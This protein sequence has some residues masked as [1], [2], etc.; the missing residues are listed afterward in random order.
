MLSVL[1][2]LVLSSSP[3]A[4][5][6]TGKLD[7]KLI[8]SAIHA[9]WPAI[10]RCVEEAQPND[11]GLVSV[12]FVIG[13]EGRVTTAELAEPSTAPKVVVQCVL[14]GVMALKTAAPRGGTVE[15]VFPFRIE[16]RGEE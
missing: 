6:Y 2:A 9:Q 7:P 5:A 3:D 11:G 13:R 4:G 8:T 15:V 1:A 14:T 16:Y 10:R 12:R